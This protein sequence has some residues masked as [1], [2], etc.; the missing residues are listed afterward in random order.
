MYYT[1]SSQCTH[2]ILPINI[3]KEMV[4][5]SGGGGGGASLAI[6][7]KNSE[8]VI[9]TYILIKR[10]ILSQQESGKGLADFIVK[11]RPG[12]RG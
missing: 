3:L 4:F 12:A 11:T 2:Y 10:N 7:R 8:I 9:T 1:G 5:L 6:R